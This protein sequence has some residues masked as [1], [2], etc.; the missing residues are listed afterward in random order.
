MTNKEVRQYLIELVDSYMVNSNNN[1]ETEL[2][3]LGEFITFL[4]E[5]QEAE[6]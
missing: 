4:N 3:V 6:L 2:T 1:T 5:V